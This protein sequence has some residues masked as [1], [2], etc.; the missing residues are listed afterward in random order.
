METT[1]VIHLKGKWEK[2]EKSVPSD[3][4]GAMVNWIGAFWLKHAVVDKEP[5]AVVDPYTPV[6]GPVGPTGSQAEA[7]V[8]SALELFFESKKNKFVTFDMAGKMKKL[9][10]DQIFHLVMWPSSTA[11]RELA[12]QKKSKSFVCADIKKYALVQLLGRCPLLCI[13]VF[14]GSCRL[15]ATHA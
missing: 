14:V 13:C 5:V 3:I 9:Q 8:G 11:V 12:T 4:S 10:L 15:N 6:V 7:A 2:M 1:Q